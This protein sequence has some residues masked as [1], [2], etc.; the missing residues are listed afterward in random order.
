MII[1]KLEVS[2]R[3]TNASKQK[4]FHKDGREVSWCIIITMG[5]FKKVRKKNWI[6][7]TQMT[8]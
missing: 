7:K 1:E 3:T 4:R 8:A 5:G 2:N 6:E